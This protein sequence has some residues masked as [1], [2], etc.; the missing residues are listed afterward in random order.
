VAA[1]ASFGAQAQNLESAIMPGPVI[2]GHAD[3]EG[4]CDNCHVR[5]DRAGQTKLCLDCHKPV[6][7]D[8]AA[9]SGY[10]GRLPPK[11]RACRSCHT[12]HKGRAA[13]IVAFDEKTF[14]HAQTDFAL[15]GKHKPAKCAGCHRAG[16]K[17]RQ[18][19]ADCLA[20]HRKDDKHKGG[21][22]AKC[23]NCHGESTWKDARFDH[24]K[25]KFP[26]R[27]G[28]A[29][30]TLKCETCHVDQKYVDTPRECLAC[31]RDDDM[32]KGHK[33]QFGARCEKCHDE[34]DWK[35]PIFNHDR[36]TQYP[37]LDRH[38]T[39]K[40]GGCHRTQLF[41]DKTPTRC[42]ACHRKDDAHKASLGD[43][44]DN[45]HSARG[46][47]NARFD[48]DVDTQFTLRDK[49]KAA[50]CESCHKDKH[51]REK[52]SSDCLACHERDDR[53]KGHR[54]LFGRKC[55]TCHDARAFK[56]SLFAHDR[57]TKFVLAG[58]HAKVSC[59]ACHKT[60]L[61]GTKTKTD[62]YAC[63]KDQDVHFATY[64]LDCAKCHMPDDWRRI[65]P[66]APLPAGARRTPAAVRQ[67]G[68]S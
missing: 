2:A 54:G 8:V 46:W 25:T 32:K 39:V 9:G 31:H 12:D 52:L 19:P 10:H 47:K 51:V 41:R 59:A 57:D 16:V 65:R 24:A 42:I 27:R 23:E 15:R 66:D 44:C 26:L 50:K 45:C 48:H 4:N 62:C 43:K 20:C 56:P 68:G 49:H 33:G 3:I 6:R 40:C 21:L 13:K 17:H 28:H 55:G 35:A 60:A 34:G 58:K 1:T 11:G 29:A 7:A 37:L 53:E 36:N 14:D 61:Y 5:F 22:G 18:A 38:R 67:G 64:D 30:A 63:H